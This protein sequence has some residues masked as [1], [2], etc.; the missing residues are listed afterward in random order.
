MKEWCVRSPF[1][2]QVL[3]TLPFDQEAAVEKCVEAAYR[4]S[5]K[6]QSWPKDKR[7]AFLKSVAAALSQDS[8]EFVKL[9]VQEG[10]KPLQDAKVESM[11]AVHCIEAAVAALYEWHGKEIPMGLSAAT[12]ERWAM[13][14]REPRGLVLAISAFNHPLNLIVHQV[15]PALAVGCPVLIKPSLKT[16]LTGQR[17]HKLLVDC[18]LPAHWC[19][20]LLIEDALTEKLAADPRL[21]VVSFIGS[22]AVGWKLKRQMAPGALAILEHGGTAPL[23][24][25]ADADLDSA[26]PLIIKGGYYHAGQVCVSV[27][28]VFVQR[29]LLEAC[30]ERLIAAIEKLRTGDPLDPLTDVGPLIQAEAADRVTQWMQQ[31]IAG[32]GKLLC[33]GE[34]LRPGCLRPILIENA[35]RNSSWYE[36][37]IFGPGMG[38]YAYD[39]L[40]ECVESINQSRFA[41]QAAIFTQNMA[42]ALQFVQ[43]I[44]ASTVLINDHTAFRADWMPFGGRKESGQGMGGIQPSMMELS[45]EKLVI[46]KSP[47]NI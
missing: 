29:Q 6:P 46:M 34:R 19:Q 11:R 22:A 38:L 20:L 28:N 40:N 26:I 14:R 15:I 9:I 32:G 21:S 27:Q 35:P 8:E 3:A 30:R 42:K 37:E 18:G 13:T 41:F 7:V 23:I 24:I 33:G 31:A 39:H 47:Y 36:D 43:E 5:R 10:G 4:L 16:P 45:R 44:D 2:Q 17:F 1:D 12:K 25:E